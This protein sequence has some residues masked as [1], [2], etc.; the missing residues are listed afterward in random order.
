MFQQ[1]SQ[2]IATAQTHVTVVFPNQFVSTPEVV[3]AWVQNTTDDPVRSI[4]A[5]VVDS[6]NLGFRVAL[7][8]TTNSANYVLIWFA[9]DAQLVYQILQT[10]RKTSEHPLFT[11]ALLDNDFVLMTTTSP[12]L[13]TIKVRMSLLR[14]IF[15]TLAQVPAS[16]TSPGRQGQLAVGPAHLYSHDGTLWGRSARTTAWS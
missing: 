3:A 16:P 11:G 12:V 2:A 13:Q 7:D 15:A 14:S 4:S 1:S 8:Q 5:T 6:D 10:G 9:G